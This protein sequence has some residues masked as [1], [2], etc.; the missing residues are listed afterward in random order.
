MCRSLKRVAGAVVVCGRDGR[1]GSA[2]ANGDGV[3][4]TRTGDSVRE[5]IDRL[6][7]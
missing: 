1:D 7:G 4:P 6:R 5:V 3:V 2:G